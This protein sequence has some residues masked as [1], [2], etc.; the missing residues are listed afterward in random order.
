MQHIEKYACGLIL[1]LLG[2]AY[3]QI[4]QEKS[5]TA[6]IDEEERKSRGE[7]EVFEMM[8]TLR[9]LE[10][11]KVKDLLSLNVE[12]LSNDVAMKR[13][14]TEASSPVQGVCHVLKRFGGQWLGKYKAFDGDKF[15]CMDSYT[16]KDCLIYSFGISTQW[17]FEDVMDSLKCKAKPT[18]HHTA[19]PLC[20]A[21]VFT[22]SILV[23]LLKGMRHCVWK[24]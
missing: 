1:V 14:Y 6:G 5:P 12:K 4:L 2:F 23:L 15:I 21:A 3:L 24:L 11:P 22:S 13:F 10:A 20:V 17:G 18:I 9:R 7:G 19:T 8:R 16:P